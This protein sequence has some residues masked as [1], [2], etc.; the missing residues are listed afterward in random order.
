VSYDFAETYVFGKQSPGSIHCDLIAQVPLLPKLRGD[1]A[2]FLRESYLALLSIFYP[3]TCVSLRYSFSFSQSY[4]LFLETV[5]KFFIPLQYKYVSS[6]GIK[7]E[8]FR[9]I[10]LISIDY[11]FRPRL[12][13]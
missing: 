13:C 12:R 8:K 10:N 9:N 6:P 4:R 2:E 5:E 3:P 1:F 11:A 7:N